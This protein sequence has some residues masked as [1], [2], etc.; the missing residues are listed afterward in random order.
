MYNLRERLIPQLPLSAWSSLPFEALGGDPFVL[1]LRS[2]DAA[3]LVARRIVGGIRRVLASHR[4]PRRRWSRREGLG[5]GGGARDLRVGPG[6]DLR[7]LPL[8]HALSR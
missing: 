7:A 8:A 2:Q 5:S 6:P 1:T 4:V 3:L